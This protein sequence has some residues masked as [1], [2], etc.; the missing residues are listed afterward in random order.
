MQKDENGDNL[1][2]HNPLSNPIESIAL[3]VLRCPP[4]Y[5]RFD[6]YD[7]QFA[8]IDRTRRLIVLHYEHKLIRW[9]HVWPPLRQ[10]LVQCLIFNVL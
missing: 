2:R 8:L 4:G 5:W 3:A 6:C 7:V 10:L 9:H 1:H